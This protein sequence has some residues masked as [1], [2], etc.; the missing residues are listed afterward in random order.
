MEKGQDILKKKKK[1]TFCV[2]QKKRKPTD[3]ERYEGIN[4]NKKD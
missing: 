3:L 2:I 4:R 1:N